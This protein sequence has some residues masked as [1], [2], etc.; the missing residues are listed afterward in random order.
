MNPIEK[1]LH[2]KACS[3]FEQLPLD[4]LLPIAEVM[5]EQAAQ[6]GEKIF[7]YGDHTPSSVYLI[8]EGQVEIR[9]ANGELM[10]ILVG[11]DFFGEEA[12]IAGGARSYEATCIL[13]CTFLVL[14]KLHF[15]QILSDC[16]AVTGTLL[17]AYTRTT[18]FRKR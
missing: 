13:P 17:T 6:Y 7:R 9:G 12:I 16:S 14:S 18:P 5:E 1:A 10:G 11:G 15:T 8:T 3:L 2:L 4:V